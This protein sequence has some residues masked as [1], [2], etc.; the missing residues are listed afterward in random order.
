MAVASSA[1]RPGS[2]ASAGRRFLV[3][4]NVAVATAI[5]VAVVVV[6]QLIAFRL[7]G[8]LDMTSTGV[9]SLSE[10]SEK[11]LHG[12]DKNVRI[13]SL[14]F[15]TDRED[16]DQP[17]YRR[18]AQD[19]LDLYESMNRAKVSS[20][21]VNP[22]KDHGKYSEITTRLRGKA[23]FKK[24][25]AA[26][27]EPIKRFTDELATQMGSLL[28][29]ELDQIRA[30]GAALGDSP[31]QA[32]IGQVD[33]AIQDLSAMLENAR[34]QVAAA[35]VPDAPQYSA[36][37]QQ[38][39]S[40]YPRF[41]QTLQNIGKFGTA[42][43]QRGAGLTPEQ[44]KFLSE[45]GNRYAAVVSKLEEEQTKVQKLEP[46]KY[47]DLVN[48]VAPTSNAILVET[49]DDA[50]VVDFSSVW[51]PVQEGD[52]RAAMKDRSFKGEEKLTSAIL[53]VTHKEQTAVVWVRYGGQPLFMGGFMPGQPQAPYAAMKQQLEDAN[54][55]VDEWDLKASVTPPTIE[56][57]PTRTIYI[58][59][60]PTPPQQG[61]MGQPSGEAP[62]GESQKQAI[63]SAI[64]DKGRALF[65][66]GWFP[67]MFG[68]IPAT[69]EYGDYLKDKWG[70]TVDSMVMLVEM[71]SIK[72][73]EYVPGRRDFFA[74]RDP[75]VTDH[76]IVSGAL[77]RQL[78]LPLC[79][80]LEFASPAPE[81]VEV[82]RLVYLPKRDGIWGVNNLQTYQDQFKR[83]QYLSLA[84]GDREGPFDLAA[85]AKKGDAKIVVI[86]GAEF[87]TD[88]VA[89]AR[90]LV[91]TS[92]GL[93]IRMTNP[94]NAS[95]LINS[96]HWLNDNTEFMN[97]GKPI[98]TGVLAVGSEAAIK[99]VQVLTIFAW[100]LL[101]VF[102]GG[103]VWWVR[104]R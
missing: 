86:S 97:I 71:A 13:T 80:P 7:P 46:L 36:A 24:E 22:L 65:V 19:L 10:G 68:A 76:P 59:L 17:R 87:A 9:N 103:L 64:G 84:D 50:R 98:D 94:G 30:F 79:A 85:A 72:P 47:D 56:P 96:L 95:L 11:L 101:A 51:P 32:A 20:E 18:T 70:I 25:I 26:Y 39:T 21:W 44:T 99:K 37:T 16:E 91:A 41:T 57:A 93:G 102:G 3:G 63:L 42:T 33:N 15:E 73:G 58:V 66:A 60:K 12:L 67:G 81:G 6:A 89:F 54:F 83:R 4:T 8:R 45:A 1:A 35:T 49:D 88:G 69:Y 43:V 77:T 55:V 34:E 74:M 104:R 52:V 62:F 78:G 28:Q 100:P 82:S 5:V 75:A 27:E 61:A 90:A 40:L 48:Q 23:S 29:G 38:L 2:S 31:A 53:R 14:Y 92:R